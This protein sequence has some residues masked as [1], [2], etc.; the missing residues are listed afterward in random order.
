MGLDITKVNKKSTGSE[1]LILSCLECTTFGKPFDMPTLFCPGLHSKA[2]TYEPTYTLSILVTPLVFLV[3]YS[4][5][6]LAYPNTI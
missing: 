3:L 4:L 1:L 2:R 5:Q 6:I